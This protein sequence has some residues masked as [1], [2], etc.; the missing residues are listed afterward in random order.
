MGG[1]ISQDG[2]LLGAIQPLVSIR[3][4]WS[5]SITLGNTIESNPFATHHCTKDTLVTTALQQGVKIACRDADQRWLRDP[6]TS[7]REVKPTDGASELQ[8]VSA[9]D[10]R[11]VPG[12]AHSG[13]R[14]D[15]LPHPGWG[16]A[17]E[18]R[19]GGARLV[20]SSELLADELAHR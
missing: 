9:T 3:P 16:R 5:S 18:I 1:A 10:T 7:L 14:E 13:W 11:A 12:Y 15:A 17:R 8:S 4:C 19:N 20:A 2:P 6:A